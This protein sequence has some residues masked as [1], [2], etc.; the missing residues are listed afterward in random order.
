MKQGT[1]FYDKESRRYNFHYIDEDGDKRDY[2]GIHCGEVF[3]FRLN[4]VWIPARVEMGMDRE[5]YLVGLPGLKL[6]GLQVLWVYPDPPILTCG[7]FQGFPLEKLFQVRHHGVL[8][9]FLCHVPVSSLNFSAA[10]R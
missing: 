5:W 4:E 8:Q 9:K 10:S 7:I 2:G 6:D 3:E 1:L